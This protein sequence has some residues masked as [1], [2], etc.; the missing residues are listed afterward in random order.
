MA[1]PAFFVTALPMNEVGGISNV[2]I[3]AGVYVWFIAYVTLFASLCI[4]AKWK[5][6][7]QPIPEPQ[8]DIN[9]I[10]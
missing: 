10:P 6:N 4:P 9:T 7:T 5:R 3:K 1:I 2:E 8:P